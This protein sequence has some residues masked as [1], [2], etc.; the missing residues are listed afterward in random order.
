MIVQLVVEPMDRFA[1]LLQTHEGEV[2]IT[3]AK[4]DSQSQYSER[5]RVRPTRELSALV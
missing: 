1:A 3:R 5:V 2:V 4:S